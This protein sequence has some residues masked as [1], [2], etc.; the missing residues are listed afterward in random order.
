MRKRRLKSALITTLW[1]ISLSVT[2]AGF[3]AYENP[4]IAE[5]VELTKP[6]ERVERAETDTVSGA[7]SSVAGVIA[8]GRSAQVCDAIESYP[9]AS[10]SELSFRS[11]VVSRICQPFIRYRRAELDR[12]GDSHSDPY[13]SKFTWPSRNEMAKRGR[14]NIYTDQAY[15][16]Q[17]PRLLTRVNELRQKATDLCCAPGDLQCRRGMA[18][19]A[20]TVCKPKSDP[21]Q[22]DPCV[23]GGTFRMPGA[24]YDSIFRAIARQR[25]PGAAAELRAIAEQNLTGARGIASLA[26]GPQ[27]GSITLTSY[28]SEDGG[29]S[30]MEPVILH[31]LGHACSM[32]KMQNA[33]LETSTPE[34]SLK[35]LRAT[36]WLDSAKKRCDP[37]YRIPEAVDDFWES[38]GESRELS[39]CL[40]D[41]ATLNQ[42]N[43]IDKPCNGLCAGHYIEESVGIAFSLLLGNLNGGPDGVFPNTCDHVRDGQHPMVSDVADCLMQHSPRFR[44][45]MREA[46]GCSANG[47]SATG[48]VAALTKRSV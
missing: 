5:R 32:V 21:N 7:T 3:V 15:Q 10:S 37:N 44:A 11:G 41:I 13:L 16:A 26:S 1:S 33:A 23:F 4:K 14:A 17:L 20:V 34:L 22:P 28:V 6:T 42:K 31:E 48:P 47:T 39:S 36:K 35:A 24:G 8:T 9:R 18:D 12:C 38:I 30:A 45:R 2:V 29:T 46:Y 19:V 40:K 25:G 43:Q 27:S